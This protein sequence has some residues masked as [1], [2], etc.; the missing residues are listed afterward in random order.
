MLKLNGSIFNSLKALFSA[1][2]TIVLVVVWEYKQRSWFVTLSC[3]ILDQCHYR[4][5]LMAGIP[6][7]NVSALSELIGL[8]LS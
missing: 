7:V 4:T 8:G 6:Q 2:L 1:S 5:H 3:Q